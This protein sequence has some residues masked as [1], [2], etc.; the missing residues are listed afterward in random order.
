MPV[1]AVSRDDWVSMWVEERREE[2]VMLAV[3]SLPEWRVCCNTCE[4]PI[5][6]GKHIY[7][8]CLGDEFCDNCFD[9]EHEAAGW[10]A[11]IEKEQADEDNYWESKL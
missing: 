9:R 10:H 11:L 1:G 6:L 4:K 8:D 2:C 7:R 3:S 5:P